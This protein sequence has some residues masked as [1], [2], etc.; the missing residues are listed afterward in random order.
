MT[1]IN[2]RTFLAEHGKFQEAIDI[3]REAAKGIQYK[4]RIYSSHFALWDLLFEKK[5][6]PLVVV[7]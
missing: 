6:L 5:P 7:P 4:Y 1:V 2:R 3:L